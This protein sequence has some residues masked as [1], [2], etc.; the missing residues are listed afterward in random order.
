MIVKVNGIEI[1]DT[2]GDWIKCPYC[3]DYNNP[4]LEW[5]HYCPC[6][7]QA[8]SIEVTYGEF[9]PQEKGD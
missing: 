6:C 2:D 5:M 3:D 4:L 8:V 9:V 1:N 7:G